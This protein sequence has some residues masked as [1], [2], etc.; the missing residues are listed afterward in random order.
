MSFF[1]SF[2]INFVPLCMWHNEIV[3]A[4][5]TLF[6][7]RPSVKYIIWS[8]TSICVFFT[9]WDCYFSP[10]TN[11]SKTLLLFWRLAFKMKHIH[12]DIL[13]A[14]FIIY[15]WFC[16]VL[17]FT[18]KIFHPQTH[19]CALKVTHTSTVLRVFNRLSS[20]IPKIEEKLPIFAFRCESIEE[21][22]VNWLNN[23]TNPRFFIN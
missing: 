15:V 19:V 8:I 21:I 12:L 18:N 10:Q 3:S 20:R 14:L 6:K 2:N 13:S 11:A 17:C 23:R 9:L 22:H 7:L 4:P 1:F 16:Y 5:V